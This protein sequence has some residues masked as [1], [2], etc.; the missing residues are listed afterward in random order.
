LETQFLSPTLHILLL[1]EHKSTPLE[2][3]TISMTGEMTAIV[4]RGNGR[5]SARK[6][7]IYDIISE[8]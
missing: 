2:E 1:N 5:A 6:Q 7:E 4:E 8:S 3:G